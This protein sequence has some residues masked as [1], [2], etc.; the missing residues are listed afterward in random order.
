MPSFSD[1][2][3]GKLIKKFV[4]IRHLLFSL[5]AIHLTP[6]HRHHIHHR[7][8]Q[9]KKKRKRRIMESVASP[10]PTLN[11]KHLNIRKSYSQL[12][13]FV[14]MMVA[15]LRIGSLTNWYNWFGWL[16]L[17]QPP[18]LDH[19]SQLE[20]QNPWLRMHFFLFSP[21]AS[22]SAITLSSILHRFGETLVLLKAW[23]YDAIYC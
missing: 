13:E 7:D 6:K 16:T 9:Q 22:I 15:D 19:L 8:K 12:W 4:M 18:A 3:H 5:S 2:A 23:N 14:W 10:L 17:H 21:Q 20:N 11:E 1:L